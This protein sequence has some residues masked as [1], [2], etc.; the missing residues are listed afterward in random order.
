MKHVLVIYHHNL[1]AE[2][3]GMQRLNDPIGIAPNCDTCR[4]FDG[5]A[6]T[7]MQE[8]MQ[9]EDGIQ[10]YH[11]K[12]KFPDAEIPEDGIEHWFERLK[13]QLPEGD[14][15]NAIVLPYGAQEYPPM[16]DW[17]KQVRAE[18]PGLKVMV[19]DPHASE[20]FRA[21]RRL[22]KFV[23]AN[24]EGARITNGIRKATATPE[25]PDYTLH[26]AID[27]ATINLRDDDTANALRGLLG[28]EPLVAR[29]PS[30]GV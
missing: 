17:L 15:V 29:A 22:P 20:L 18:N 13:A 7:A 6:S 14:R 3:L 12:H 2:F 25:T 1:S 28:M 16:F 5:Q 9:S 26:P 24:H 19:T 23:Q 8:A 10:F 11:F 27:L 4:I 30:R 21:D